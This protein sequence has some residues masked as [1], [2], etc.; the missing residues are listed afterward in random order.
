MMSVRSVLAVWPKR[1]PKRSSG[2]LPS[3]GSKLPTSPSL[4]A[5]APPGGLGS[6]R[7]IASCGGSSSGGGSQLSL[8][9]YSTP[10][11]AYAEIIPAFEKTP[12]GDGVSISESYGNSGDQARGVI[13]GKPADI[14]ALSLEPDIT[15]LVDA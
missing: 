14:V 5:G 3:A 8:T 2:D 6:A 12:A 10:K 7:D 1:T 11:E 4:V 13:A 15:K 9:A